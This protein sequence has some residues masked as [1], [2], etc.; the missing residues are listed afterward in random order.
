[1]R[2]VI[3]PVVCPGC[4]ELFTPIRSVQKTCSH[5]C[6]A[7]L[8]SMRSRGRQVPHMNAARRVKAR[9]R[10]E[11]LVRE[12][13]GPITERD[14]KLFNF[15]KQLGYERGYNKAMSVYRHRKTA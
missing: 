9:A 8:L 2:K 12:Q 6:R 1:M 11:T 13:F 14:A 7:R 3:Q 10:I 5:T 4:V 15:A